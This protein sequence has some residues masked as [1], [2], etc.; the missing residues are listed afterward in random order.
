MQ[1]AVLGAAAG[2]GFPQWNSNATGCRRSRAGDPAAPARTQTGLAVSADGENWVLLNAAPELATQIARSPF[3]HPRADGALRNS[4]IAAVVL[5]GGD[6]DAVAGLLTLRE[7]HPFAIH[8]PRQVL[9]VLDAN[10]IFEVLARDIVPRRALT[11]DAPEELQGADGAPLGL[12]LRLFAVPGKVPL[13]QEDTASGAVPE[14]VADGRTVGVEV[15]AGPAR[16][17]FIP[18]CGGFPPA[19]AE[20]LHRAALVFFDGTL[21]DDD[22]MIRQGA[23]TKTGLRM[24]HM[25]MNGP[26]GTMAAFAGLG[27]ARKVFVHINNTNPA[28]LADSPERRAAEAAGWIV[29]EDG[30]RFEL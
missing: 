4:P 6:V 15:S 14:L 30:M 28:L 26:H 10:P 23:G 21:W 7:R 12:T 20:R 8:A 19:L 9:D 16:C 17:Y 1:I 29:G 13:Y 25:S 22:E 27:V 2:G 18:G 5:T 3:L 24:G 11:L